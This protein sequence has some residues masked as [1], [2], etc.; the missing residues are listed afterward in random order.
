MQQENVI[1]DRT[2]GDFKVTMI[3]KDHTF[4][5]HIGWSLLINLVSGFFDFFHF[6]PTIIIHETTLLLSLTR[7][8]LLINQATT[9][10]KLLLSIHQAHHH[11]SCPSTR[12]RMSIKLCLPMPG[13]ADGHVVSRCQVLGRAGSVHHG[14]DQ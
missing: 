14:A 8:L 12:S 13:T 2:G 9:I 7:L 1:I 6:H 4:V 10:H 11:H 3:I 5:L